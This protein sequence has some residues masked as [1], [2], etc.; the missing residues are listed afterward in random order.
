[1]SSNSPATFL[2]LKCAQTFRL[3]FPKPSHHPKNK[4]V[5][6]IST[7]YLEG[8][9]KGI[10][11]HNMKNNTFNK[12]YSYEQGFKPSYHGQFIDSKN[13]LLYIFGLETFGIFDLNTNVMNANTKNTLGDCSEFPKSTYIPSPINELHILADSIHYIMD[14]NNKNINKM[15]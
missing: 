14:M 1:M 6:R 4:D 8:N 10:Y 9:K 7:H 12:I 5:V 11:E 3:Y 15:E 2:K 13:E